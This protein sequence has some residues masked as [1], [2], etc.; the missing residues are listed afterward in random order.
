MLSFLLC[1][2][3]NTKQISTT[4]YMMDTVI[5]LTLFDA[6][7][8]ILNNAVEQSKKFEQLLSVTVE[9]SDVDRINKA[10]DKAVEVS[11]DTIN[12]LNTAHDISARSNGA[13]DVT[14]LPLTQLW[15]IKNAQSIP[16][17]R[18]ILDAVS[19]VDY[20]NISIDKN[21][22]STANGATIDLGG[23]AKGYIADRLREYL[24]SEGVENAIINLG[25][26][27]VVMGDKKDKPYA[28]GIQKPFHPHGEL[29]ATLYIKN[30]SAVTSGTYERYFIADN[31]VYHHVIDPLTGMPTDNDL[32]SVTVIADSSCIADAL[33]TA[34]LIL[35]VEKSIPLLKH[36]SAEAVFINSEQIITVTDGLLTEKEQEQISIKL[37]E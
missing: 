29:A 1:S 23:I 22:V 5:T 20:N 12:I 4:Q 19:K 16:N 6:D 8:T 33:A 25:G 34:C 2:C 11:L 30:K 7:D 26:N 15:D 18:K 3:D 24:E 36:Y 21:T 32:Q 28:I 37:K 17:S 10:N 27:V 9:G 31:K 35:G 14:V 13:F